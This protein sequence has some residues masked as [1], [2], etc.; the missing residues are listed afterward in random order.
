LKKK[1]FLSEKVQKVT[2]GSMGKFR[3]QKIKKQH[4]KLHQ[5]MHSPEFPHASLMVMWFR[6]IGLDRSAYMVGHV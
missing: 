2:L 6:I 4:E 5:K 1:I 3:N